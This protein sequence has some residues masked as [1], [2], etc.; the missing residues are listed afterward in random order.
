MNHAIKQRLAEKNLALPQ[1]QAPKHSYVPARRAGD[2]LFLSGKTTLV[3][4]TVRSVGHVG[5]DLTIE[6]GQDAARICALNLLAQMEVE[7]GLENV[8]AV[9]KLTGFVACPEN[10]D[11]QAT[12]MNAASD[13]FVDVLGEV[14]Q[15][16]RSA[17]GVS[18]LPGGTSVEIDAIVLLA[19]SA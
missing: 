3:D 5:S 7:V 14:G 1:L 4:G 11:G 18:A 17:V 10:F 2:V 12:V 19:P 9:V 6:E 16:A 8:A 13:L 15:H